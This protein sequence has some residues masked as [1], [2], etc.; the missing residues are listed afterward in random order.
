MRVRALLSL[1]RAF[2]GEVFPA[3][4]AVTVEWGDK[5]VRFRAYVDGPVAGVDGDSLSGVSAEIAAD[6]GPEVTVDYEILRRD[7]PAPIHDQGV[8]VFHRKEQ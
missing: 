2:L 7:A 1:Q 4:R 3:L 5:S 6:F 8:W